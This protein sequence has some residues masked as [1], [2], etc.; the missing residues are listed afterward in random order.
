MVAHGQQPIPIIFDTDIGSDIDDALA[1]A[2]ALQSPELD[3]RAVT[4][5]S[6]DTVGRSRLAWKE[7]GLY[8]RHDIPLATGAPEPLVGP[9][10][11]ER[12]PPQFQ[13]LTAQDVLP[14]A[15]RRRAADLIV[16]TFLV[17][18]I[19][20]WQSGQPDRYPTLHDPLAM[21]V[22]FRAGLVE[23]QL[24]RVEVETAGA[25]G[26]GL[27]LFTPAGR[28]PKD[29]TPSTLIARQVNVR[30]FL[31]LLVERLSAPPRGK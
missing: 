4:T 9:A 1:L 22:V 24:G 8:G 10:L 7:M 15:A 31:D 25:V 3:V 20:L 26:N 23:T 5:V 14:P 21:A 28:L 18:L 29:V 2:L 16:D 19:E 27:T 11:T 13:V 6:D 17:R 12:V 30:G